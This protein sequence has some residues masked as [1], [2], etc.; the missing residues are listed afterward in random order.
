M[1][2]RQARPVDTGKTCVAR[3]LRPAKGHLHPCRRWPLQ[4]SLPLDSGNWAEPH[5]LRS[6]PTAVIRTDKPD[7]SFAAMISLAAALIN[8]R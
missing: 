2:W 8:S 3:S 4:D 6:A 1:L 5:Y 7:Q